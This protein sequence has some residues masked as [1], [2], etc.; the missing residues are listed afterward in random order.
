MNLKLG[1]SLNKAGAPGVLSLATGSETKRGMV[2]RGRGGRGRGKESQTG[3]HN[4]NNTNN[5]KNILLILQNNCTI[6]NNTNNK[7]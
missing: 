1:G 7:K 2:G 3:R 4:L 5:T 6:Q